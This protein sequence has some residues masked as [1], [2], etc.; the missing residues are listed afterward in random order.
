MDIFGVFYCARKIAVDDPLFF[1]FGKE[2]Q[3]ACYRDDKCDGIKSAERYSADDRID[4]KP[5][6]RGIEHGCGGY[7][8]ADTGNT[9]FFGNTTKEYAADNKSVINVISTDV[10]AGDADTASLFLYE[11]LGSSA[12]FVEF[13]ALVNLAR[14]VECVNKLCPRSFGFTVYKNHT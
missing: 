9:V 10:A 14:V 3:N 5:E 7:D 6:D 12:F 1:K 11:H 2:H 4:K 8:S 13:H